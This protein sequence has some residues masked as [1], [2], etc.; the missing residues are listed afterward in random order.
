M[1]QLITVLV[2]P[3]G[4]GGISRLVVISG[5]FEIGGELEEI[6]MVVITIFYFL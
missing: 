1:Q 3:G 6:I 4:G 5:E 2:A